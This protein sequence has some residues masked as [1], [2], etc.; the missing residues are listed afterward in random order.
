MENQ[1]VIDDAELEEIRNGLIDYWGNP[2][3]KEMS[4]DELLE[5]LNDTI[6]REYFPDQYDW[7]SEY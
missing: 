2:E 3:L 6:I 5:L 4:K 7:D 1:N